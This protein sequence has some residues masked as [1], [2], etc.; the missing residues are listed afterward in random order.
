MNNSKT[1]N[2]ANEILQYFSLHPN[3]TDTVEGIAT[4]WVTSQKNSESSQF[5]QD[6]LDY[7]VDQGKV[8][9]V[10]LHDG[11]TKYSLRKE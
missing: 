9:I 3:A 7:L 4:W 10:R 11:S 5:A 2:I 6:A 1:V 8:T